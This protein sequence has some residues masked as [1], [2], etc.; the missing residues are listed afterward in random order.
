MDILQN[1]I[2]N[3]VYDLF[4]ITLSFIFARYLYETYFMKWLWGGWCIILK[5]GEKTITEREM[6]PTTYKRIKE[7]D[8]ELSVYIKGVV[9]PFAWINIDV[10]SDEARQSKFLQWDQA[11]KL[12]IIDLSKNKDNQK[13]KT[14]PH[15]NTAE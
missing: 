1:I 2:Q 4:K 10:V 13:T 7:D 8:T 11:N 5:E 14:H 3:L 9:S 12:I 6:S 15:N